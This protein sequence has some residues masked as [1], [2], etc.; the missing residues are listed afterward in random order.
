MFP[1]PIDLKQDGADQPLRVFEREFAIG[2][3]SAV[4][5]ERAAGDARAAG[6]ASLSGLRREAVLPA[7]H[8]ATS[9]WTLAVV[10]SAA[11]R[12]RRLATIFERIEFGNGRRRYRSPRRRPVA[13]TAAAPAAPPTGRGMAMLANFTVRGTDGGYLGTRRFPEVRSRTRRAG[14]A[15]SR[16]SSRA[17]DRSRSCCSSFSAAWR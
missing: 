16:D 6:A 9:N 1:E 11:A 2:V 4:A 8:G 13:P 10:G 17:A 15:A 5:A 7:D 14:V 3:G 12:R